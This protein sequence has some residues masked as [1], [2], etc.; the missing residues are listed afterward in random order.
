MV[1]VDDAVV[2]NSNQGANRLSECKPGW[3]MQR[4]VMV[5]NKNDGSNPGC[6]WRNAGG[7]P[8]RHLISQAKATG[9]SE[10]DRVKV[11]GMDA[12]AQLNE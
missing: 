11:E 9:G 4:G 8:S 1:W 6:A 7:E 5:W 10:K 3:S 2:D 12:D